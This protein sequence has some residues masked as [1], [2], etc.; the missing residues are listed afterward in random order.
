ML[1][2]VNYGAGRTTI[3]VVG[4]TASGKSALMDLVPRLFDPQEGEILMDG[5]PIRDIARRIAARDRLRPQ[6]SFCSATPSEQSG[7]MNDM[8][9]GPWAAA[10]RARDIEF[11]SGY[12]TCSAARVNLSGGQKQRA[13]GASLARKRGVL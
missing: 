6:E 5:V 12:E 10:S 2:H 4:A 7:A 1:R 13:A 8:R 9:G 3:G 11:P